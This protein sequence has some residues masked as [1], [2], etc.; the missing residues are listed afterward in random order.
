MTVFLE[1]VLQLLGKANIS[2]NKLLTDLKLG[3]NSF[4]NWESRGTIPNGET[5]SKIAAYFGVSIE[6]L[7]GS[8]QPSAAEEVKNSIKN[9]SS[10]TS[11]AREALHKK[12]ESM[13]L[14]ELH[15]VDQFMDFLLS[16]EK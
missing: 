14:D 7:L 16:K 10:P 12:L 6:Y 5:L 11:A 8:E 15:E 3:K 4:V 1:N 9:E 2:K 13:S